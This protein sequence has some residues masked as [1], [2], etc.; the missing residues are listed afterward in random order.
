MFEC[1]QKNEMLITSKQMEDGVE[2]YI[3]GWTSELQIYQ[4]ILTLIDVLSKTSG[5]SPL[6]IAHDIVSEFL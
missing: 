6:R 5:R 4:T 3:E 1:K 2:V